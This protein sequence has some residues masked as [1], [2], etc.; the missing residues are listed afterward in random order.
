MYE[1]KQHEYS[2]TLFS[3]LIFLDPRLERGGHIIDIFV[4]KQKH[5]NMFASPHRQGSGADA[6][7]KKNRAR[8][9]KHVYASSRVSASHG[10]FL[11]PSF[12]VYT[13]YFEVCMI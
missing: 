3:S 4:R 10:I 6:A 9:S 11:S 13:Q 5:I 8:T 7:N 2:I 12:V 1:M